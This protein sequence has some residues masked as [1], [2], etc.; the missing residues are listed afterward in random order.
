MS[1]TVLAAGHSVCASRR[2]NSSSSLRAPPIRVLLTQRD[3]LLNER[4]RR[5]MRQPV[6]R[7]FKQRLPAA[8]KKPRVV[9]IAVMRK[10]LATLNAML[11]DGREWEAAAQGA[12]S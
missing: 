10:M 6:R 2:R 9:S 1:V 8:G 5:C 7:A 12:L 11:R 4:R 3:Q